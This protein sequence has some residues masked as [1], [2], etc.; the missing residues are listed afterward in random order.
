[1]DSILT[2]IAGDNPQSLHT[3]NGYTGLFKGCHDR[4]NDSCEQQAAYSR[5]MEAQYDPQ[6]SSETLTN[7]P[8]RNRSRHNPR[9]P[10]I[11]TYRSRTMVR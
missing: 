2:I 3:V 6:C 1:M 8:S 7:H 4:I 11:G 10:L 9:L 5:V